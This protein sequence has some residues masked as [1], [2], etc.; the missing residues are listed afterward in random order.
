MTS[1]RILPEASEELEACVSYYNSQQLNLGT[2]LLSRPIHRFPFYVLSRSLL[3]E[4]TIVAVAHCP[5]HYVRM[6]YCGIGHCV[7]VNEAARSHMKILARTILVILVAGCAEPVRL[8][9]VEVTDGASEFERLNN[10]AAIMSELMNDGF[11][12]YGCGS[13]DDPSAGCA[14]GVSTYE[15]HIQPVVEENTGRVFLRCV[16]HDHLNHDALL[17]RCIRRISEELTK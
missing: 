3:E 16:I 12:S 9:L 10:A 17:R 11:P 5:T 15:L 7:S 13:G 14:G 2:E 6:H 8:D 1:F 4:I